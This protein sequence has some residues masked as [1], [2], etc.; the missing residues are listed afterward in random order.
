MF[1]TPRKDNQSKA[2]ILQA[3]S[4]KITSGKEVHIKLPRV[5]AIRIEIKLGFK[6][7]FKRDASSR[8]KSC[9]EKISKD[10]FGRVERMKQFGNVSS[11]SSSRS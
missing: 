11:H 4:S 10:K 2:S 3:S 5:K 9:H 1:E 7:K 8:S 6:I